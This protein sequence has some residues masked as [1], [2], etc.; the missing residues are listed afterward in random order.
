MKEVKQEI[1]ICVGPTITDENF[2]NMSSLDKMIYVIEGRKLVEML[3][4]S[5]LIPEYGEYELTY[6]NDDLGKGA[7]Y[8]FVKIGDRIFRVDMPNS[9]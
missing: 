8:P 6:N 2:Q 7:E 1:T 3:A 9:N 5:R 4:F